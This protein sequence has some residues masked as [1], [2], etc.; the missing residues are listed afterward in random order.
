MEEIKNSGEVKTEK[1]LIDQARE[2]ADRIERA[3]A[4]QRELLARQES[5]LA[6]QMLSGRSEAGFQVQPKVETPQEYSMRVL[7]GEVNPL[8]V[9]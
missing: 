4:E 5:L 6:R 1:D 7:R 8:N 9:K 3:N 2:Q